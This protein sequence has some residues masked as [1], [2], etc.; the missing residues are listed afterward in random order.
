MKM[1]VSLPTTS[2]SQT[3][4][5]ELSIRGLCRSHILYALPSPLSL[6]P[7]TGGAESPDTARDV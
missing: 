4:K 1:S 6:A 5:G 3:P 7:L 2:L